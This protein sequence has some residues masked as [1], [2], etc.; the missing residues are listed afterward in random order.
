[1]NAIAAE[2]F[3]RS[4]SPW[5]QLAQSRWIWCL[6]AVLVYVFPAINDGL[7]GLRASLGDTDDA[8]RLLQVR[9]WLDGAGWYDTTI[10]KIGGA[11][12]LVSHWS[13]LIDLPIGILIALFSLVVPLDSAETLV[14]LVWPS[15][16]L[17]VFLRV[18]VHEADVREGPIAAAVVLILSLTCLTGLY[19]FR[20]GRIDHHNAMIL[21]TIAGLL[22]L[23]R[24]LETP[25]LAFLGGGA[26][27]V[28]L[29]IGYEPLA[30][31]APLAGFAVLAG[32]I[33]RP[34]LASACGVVAG[35]ATSLLVVFAVTVEP[36]NWLTVHCD[37]ISL[38]LVVLTSL[39]TF[40]LF[41]IHTYAQTWGVP[42][43]LSA[44]GVVGALSLLA[45]LAVEPVCVGGPIARMNSEAVRLWL[46]HVQEGKSVWAMPS[47]SAVWVWGLVALL[48][49]GNWAA[50]SR[51]RHRRTMESGVLAIVMLSAVVP[52]LLMMKFHSYASWLAVLCLGLRIATMRG[53]PWLSAP[54]GRLAA[55]AALNQWSLASVVM[56]GLM[57][58]GFEFNGENDRSD[59]CYRSQHVRSMARLPEG[60]VVAPISMGPYIAALTPHRVLS[61]PYH[62][63]DAA[64]LETIRI[65]EAD[66]GEAEQMLRAMNA[67]YVVHCPAIPVFGDNQ[68]STSSLRV[69]IERGEIP[70]FLDPIPLQGTPLLVFAVKK[71]RSAS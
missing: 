50:W 55:I 29:A 71:H 18:L 14:R 42:A 28:A 69:L 48:T 24:G 44:L 26:M 61:G 11:T 8:V 52:A 53:T 4:W 67:R 22:L 33:H 3:G 40:G 20:P 35:L 56:I 68:N 6:V 46:M 60:L 38:N 30:L 5:R 16:L 37:A 34:W 59:A 64:I 19:Q 62:R 63:I 66:S 17:L 25:R 47:G 7:A 51:W 15:L 58:G 21:G 27:G 43:R 2:F 70:T 45:Y 10:S 23:A 41:L 54:F 12:P 9:A 39:A 36:S 1:M 65:F 31:I 57:A 32:T 13:R 49:A